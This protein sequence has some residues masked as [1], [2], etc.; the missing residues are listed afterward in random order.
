VAAAPF[1][2]GH[3]HGQHGAALVSHYV[4]ALAM[5]RKAH[6]MGAIFAGHMPA[7]VNFIPGGA[8][9]PV[10]AADIAAFRTILTELRGFV[11]NV[12][13]GDGE[14]LLGLFGDYTSI[15]RGCGN[16]LAYGVF[17]LNSA[18][19]SKLLARGR[20]TNGPSAPWIRLR[21]ANTCR[22]R[23]TRPTAAIVR[24]PAALR[25][26][27]REGRAYSWL[28]APRYEGAVHEVGPLARMWVNGDYRY[29]IS[30]IDRIVARALEAE[31]VADAMNGCSTNSCRAAR[32][33]RTA[34]RP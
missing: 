23:G 20:Y 13:L 34:P 18:G 26:R 33:M 19:T 32:S 1:G 3:D 2:A 5:R 12:M 30:A 16:L 4:Q 22:A 9:K 8:T 7:A 21:S 6:Q 14:A 28:K 17:D 25:S 11:S 15:G 10:T 27:R 31:K 24:R 29:G